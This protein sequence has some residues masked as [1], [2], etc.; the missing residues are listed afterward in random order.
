M[1][2]VLV[3]G[4]GGREHAIIKKITETSDVEIP[5]ALIDNQIDRMIQDIEYRLSYQGIKL[6]D[7]LKYTNQTREDYRNS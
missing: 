1:K 7:Y 2:K 6:D 4:G 5:D 3:I